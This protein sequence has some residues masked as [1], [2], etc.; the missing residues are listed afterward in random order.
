M[1][2][3]GRR[4]GGRPRARL[5][6]RV[7]E[8][9]ERTRLAAA[10]PVQGW[11]QGGPGSGPS[12]VF[13]AAR[14]HRRGRRDSGRGDDREGP[15]LGKTPRPWSGERG[16]RELHRLQRAGWAKQ[17]RLDCGEP[18][19]SRRR[20]HAHAVAAWLTGGWIGWEGEE[21]REWDGWEEREGRD[22]AL[23]DRDQ[24]LERGP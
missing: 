21:E 15:G 2:R 20:C 22:E 13:G 3:G 24:A 12:R 16:R 5:L 19:C 23:Q 10:L 14:P 17:L 9:G 8:D 4:E 18:R 7:D 6:A 11:V 1:P